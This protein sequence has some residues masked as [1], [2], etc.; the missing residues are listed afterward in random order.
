MLIFS[1]CAQST[2][3]GV[4]IQAAQSRVGKVLS[5]W[6]ILP[7]MVGFFSTMSTS[8]PASAMS[9]AVWMPAMP[10]PMTS[11][12]LVT[13]LSPAVRGALSWTLAMAA[14]PRMMAFSVPVGLVLVNPGALLADV[15][16]LHHIGVEARG[17]G[18]LAEGRLVHTGRAGA[19]DH[20]REL[21]LLDGVLDRGSGPP[22][23]TYTDS[24]W[25]RRR[26]ARVL[27]ASADRLD[28][29]GGGNVAAA[30]TYKYANSLHACLLLTCCICGTR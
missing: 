3:L 21:M 2:I 23:S 6:V 10:P 17:R 18:R 16:D 1:F 24:W 27:S 11:A 9:R 29:H 19:D 20:A 30:P 13:G 7:P 22:R 8:K 14:L 25:R 4:R 5:I 12:R 15:G 26:R 28:I